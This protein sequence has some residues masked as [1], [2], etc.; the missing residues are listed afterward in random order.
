MTLWFTCIM[1]LDAA[2]NVEVEVPNC[3]LAGS[4]SDHPHI[5]AYCAALHAA[6]LSFLHAS[7]TAWSTAGCS[8]P[9]AE[10]AE[11]TST[12]Y[13]DYICIMDGEQKGLIHRESDSYEAFCSGYCRAG[14]Q[15]MRPVLCKVL[16]KP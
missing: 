15:I 5:H 8:N 13:Q 3:C 7:E 1:P 10:Q 6:T 12:P 11:P 14:V 2:L 4:A 9:N 16:Y